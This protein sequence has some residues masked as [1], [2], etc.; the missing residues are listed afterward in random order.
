VL[1]SAW[2]QEFQNDMNDDGFLDNPL[3]KQINVLYTNAKKDG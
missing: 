3:A 2:L 1:F